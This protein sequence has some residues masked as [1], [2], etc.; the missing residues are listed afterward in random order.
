MG[1]FSFRTMLVAAAAGTLL[2]ALAPPPLASAAPHSQ[3]RPG[4]PPS[5]ADRN[6]DKVADDLE[7]RLRSAP[8]DEELELLVSGIPF[9][10]A[11]RAVGRM[12][13]RHDYTLVRGF[14]ARMN[15]GQARALSRQPEVRR[16]EPDRQVHTMDA[17]TLPDFG[18]AGAQQLGFR[19]EGVTV[20]V[21]DTGVD[22]AHEQLDGKGVIAFRDFIGSRTTAYDDHGHGTHVS[23]TA[24]GDGIGG[25]AAA[26]NRGVAPAAALVAVK[27]LDASGN[28]PDSGVV[29][30]VQW[31]ADRTD[32]DVIS[33]SLGSDVGS[34]GK[35]LLSQAVDAAVADR[36]IVVVVAAGN[37][38]DAPG[39]LGSPAAA[40]NAVTVGAVAEWSGP[41]TSYRSDGVTLAQF[42]SRGPTADGR[43]KPDVLGPGVSVLAADAGTS[44]GYVA[45][46]GTSMATPYVAGAAALAWQA[47]GS[48]A[49]PGSSGTARIRTGLESTAS[50]RGPVGK[51][52]DWGAGLVD[53]RALVA[54]LTADTSDDGRTPMPTAEHRTATVP[55]GSFV[56][57]PIQVSDLTVP[58]A[59]T[60]TLDGKLACA[61]FCFFPEWSPDLD[62]QLRSPTGTVLVESTC[63]LGSDCGTGRQET[64]AIRPTATGTYVLR[65][66]AYAG[67]AGGRFQADIS[68]GPL[69]GASIS[70]PPTNTPPV[71]NAGTDQIVRVSG[72]R[73]ASF[74]LDGR[75][76]SDQDGAISS[77]SWSLAGT[78]G[79]TVVGTAATLSQSKSAGTYT[80]SLTV[81]DN[82]GLTAVDQVVVTVAP[83]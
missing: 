34:D 16:V 19:G 36:G 42:S 47:L 82:G 41:L 17:G 67:G 1:V 45:L 58:L 26:D 52:S 54:S 14:A 10:Q 32:V 66:Y 80:Y 33:M 6:G 63:T 12:Q 39:T 81:T 20:C 18:A 7:P 74:T 8:A 69:V 76:S 13:V 22:P 9:S 60:V 68:R 65:V 3:S 83:R 4:G 78:A 28:G 43:I 59:A 25:A 56:D 57:V 29:A 5:G 62:A 21:V 61:S 24:V 70:P 30:G 37:S 48:G 79:S 50:D 77:Y 27:V 46:S 44:S 23:S 75:S 71:A 35:D 72:K 55:A 40:R 49:A 15:A 31:C 64:L 2:L 53:T 73:K 38:G 51:D 11:E